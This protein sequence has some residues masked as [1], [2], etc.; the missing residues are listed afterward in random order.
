MI[1]KMCIKGRWKKKGGN[2]E[3]ESRKYHLNSDIVDSRMEILNFLYLNT[4]I[5]SVLVP[6]LNAT[7]KACG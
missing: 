2:D 4:A 5:S 3:K 7:T 6:F 1:K